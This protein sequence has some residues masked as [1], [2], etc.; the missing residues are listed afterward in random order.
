MRETELHSAAI[1]I[2]LYT[3]LLLKFFNLGLEERLREK[4]ERLSSLQHSIL[5]MLHTETLTI[6][7][8]WAMG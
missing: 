1:E 8:G 3:A 6:L 2:Q 4:G 5:R 7:H